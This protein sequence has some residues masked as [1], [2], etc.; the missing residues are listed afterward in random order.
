MPRHTRKT[1]RSFRIWMAANTIVV[2]GLA[3]W[4]L[5]PATKDPDSTQS[6]GNAAVAEENRRQAQKPAPTREQILAI[7][8]LRFGISAP[9]AP[10]S[11]AE[12]DAAAKA[13]GA[14][15]TVVQFFVKWT[16]EFRADSI[17]QTYKQG[18]LPVISW[19]PWAGVKRGPNQTDY[20]L[21]K[22]IS[23]RF[24]DYIRRFA[25]AVRDQKWP[26]AIRF[27]HEMNGNWYP[28]SEK[29]SGN[30]PGEYAE[31]WRHVHGI[32]AEVGATN[33]IWIWS[34]N[35]IRPVPSV[36]L[37][38]LYPGDAYVDWIGMVGYAVEESTAAAVFEP[39]ITA[40]RK[41]SQKPLII[42]ETAVEKGP[43][44]LK[45]IAD[46]FAWMGNRQDIVGFIWFNFSKDEGGTSDWRF[47]VHPP[48]AEAVRKGLAG[49]KLAAP[50]P[51]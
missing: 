30:K 2:V 29:Q 46:F 27:A 22:I 42:T 49:V 36:K 47:S 3:G 11:S 14:D 7:P 50:P 32:F 9:Q 19:E 5:S 43:H 38:P 13:A 24:D 16:Q 10:W 41:F 26:V 44:Q 51:H 23:G 6:R 15:P 1:P 33:V 40:V 20:A 4:I 45:W 31:M 28:W 35:I 37:D 25:T 39:T 18:A 8:G 12:I 17:P 48:I 21:S 34:P